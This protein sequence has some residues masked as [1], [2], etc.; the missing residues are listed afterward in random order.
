[1]T[2]TPRGMGIISSP[3]VVGPVQY[4]SALYNGATN[5][6]HFALVCGCWSADM[7]ALAGQHLL[8]VI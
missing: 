7:T 4:L 1:M 8:V 5:V 2:A 6:D 3:A